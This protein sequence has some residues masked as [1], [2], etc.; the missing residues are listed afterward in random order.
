MDAKRFVTILNGSEVIQKEEP[1]DILKDDGSQELDIINVYPE[2]K[3]QKIQ[4]FGGAITAAVGDVLEKMPPEKAHEIIQS[5]FGRGGN[6]Y[7][8][9]RTHVDSCDFSP[10]QYCADDDAKDEEFSRFSIAYDQQHIIPWIKAAYAA[11]E[12]NLPVMLSPWSPPAYMKTNGLREKG[13]HLKPEYY[14]QWAKYLCRYIQAYKEQGINVT[15]LSVQNEPNAVQM[16]DSCIYAPEEER[17]FLSNYLYPAMCE[18]GIDDVELYIWDHNKERLFDRAIS[19]I[20]A[21]TNDKIAGIAFHWYSG[22]HFDALRLV[23]QCFPDKKMIFSEGCI[24][25][26]RFDKNQLVNAQKYAHDMLGNLAAGMNAFLDWNICLDEQGGPNYVG[27]YCEAPIICN[28]E[29]GE[30]D[31]KLSFYYIGHCSRYIFPQ[32]YQIATTKYKDSIPVAA[33][34]N[35]NGECVLVICNEEHDPLPVYVRYKGYLVRLELESDSIST[36]IIKK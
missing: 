22:D 20:T 33:F 30:T 26:S 4:A 17:E 2:V 13:G 28:T 25:Y 1:L 3:G 8:M 36:V 15:A 5:Y 9:I 23:R 12:E 6:G 7:R 24:E 21:E 29:T 34:E 32:A 31:Y 10:T 14:A 27:N 11:A 16:W 35:P 18:A 19:E